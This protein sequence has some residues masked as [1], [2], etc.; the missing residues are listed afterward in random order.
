[1]DLDVSGTGQVLG[2][3]A[4]S[5]GRDPLVRKLAAQE[6]V[7]LSQV[8]GTGVGGRIRKQDVE[9]ARRM[10]EGSVLRGTGARGRGH[11][12][13]GPHGTMSRLRQTF[14]EQIVES[15]HTAAQLTG[16]G[17]GCHRDRPAAGQVGE[18]FAAETGVSGLLPFFALAVVEAY[19]TEAQRGDR[20]YRATYHDTENLAVVVDTEQGV[21][22]PVVSRPLVAA[23]LARRIDDLGRGRARRGWCRTS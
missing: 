20:R 11:G 12:A 4:T 17:G 22:A 13:A 19:G 5:E 18:W 9:A 7:D 21:L 6:G 23:E 16:G 15:L 1:M 8:K 10:R 3:D 14:A 2:T